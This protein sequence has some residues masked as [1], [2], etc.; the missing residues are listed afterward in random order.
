MRIAAL[1]LAWQMESGP[2]VPIPKSAE[3]S[4]M[5][6]LRQVPNIVLS[7]D[8]SAASDGLAP[9]PDPP[10]LLAIRSGMTALVDVVGNS[11]HSHRH[12]SP[13][14]PSRLL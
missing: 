9:V 12:D 6:E 7:G 4:L 1:A 13:L 5:E 11:R 14:P 10:V 8:I 2:A 3:E